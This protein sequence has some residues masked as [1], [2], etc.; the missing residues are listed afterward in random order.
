MIFWHKFCFWSNMWWIVPS[1]KHDKTRNVDKTN[2]WWNFNKFDLLNLNNALIR[3]KAALRTYFIVWSQHHFLCWWWS[4]MVCVG[5]DLRSDTWL[6][7]EN[8]KSCNT[9]T[10]EN[11]HF[12]NAHLS[13]T[14]VIVTWLVFLDISSGSSGVWSELKWEKK[15]TH[16]SCISADIQ[17][18]PDPIREARVSSGRQKISLSFVLFRF[19]VWEEMR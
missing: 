19:L 1:A 9:F 6:K 13:L 11:D 3:W 5:A 4:P 12:I 15:R 16:A 18:C 8:E 10:Y 14:G 2:C 17:W 7:S